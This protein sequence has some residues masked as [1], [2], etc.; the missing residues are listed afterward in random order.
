VLDANGG[1]LEQQRYLPFGLPRT[2][3]PFAN[4]TSTD[5]TY[6]GQ[7]DL[8]GTG[9]M[10]YKARFYSPTLGRFT[11]PDTIIPDTANPQSWNRYSY[12]ENRP[13]TYIDSTGHSGILVITLLAVSVIA[14]VGIYSISHYNQHVNPP[15]QF[16][17]GYND[18]PKL[19]E[20]LKINQKPKDNSQNKLDCKLHPWACAI[21]LAT[22]I[23]VVV[24]TAF[25][26]I[27]GDKPGTL[28]AKMIKQNDETSNT[29]D[30]LEPSQSSTPPY[31]TLAT[32][33][34]PTPSVP[35]L[36][37]QSPSHNAPVIPTYSQ[38]ETQSPSHTV[39]GS[40]NTP[41]YFNRYDMK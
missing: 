6:T 23:T 41:Y 33:K 32:Q 8:P 39:S 10:D 17:K 18:I 27:T 40:A 2:T 11:Q 31:H 19:D 21:F 38:L 1:I 12:V 30:D 14:V 20:I 4:V 36:T 7:R 37:I 9:L 22:V 15:L 24:G 29:L 16:A 3:P 5:F 34:V 26:A 25:C 13:I 28:C 35:Q